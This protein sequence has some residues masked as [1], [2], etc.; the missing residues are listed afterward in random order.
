MKREQLRIIYIGLHPDTL[1]WVNHDDI[2][3]VATSKLEYF[4]RITLNPFN[5]FPLVIYWL[6][7]KFS[8]SKNKIL[9]K[10]L[11]LI[12]R[13]TSHMYSSFFKKYKNYLKEILLSDIVI[14]DTE[15]VIEFLKFI[16]EEKI[17]LILVNS[18]SV[19]P[20]EI[21]D[22]I[23]KG[24]INIHPSKLPKYRGSLPTLWSLKN[25]DSTSAV[26]YITLN[27]IIDGGEIITQREFNILPTD[28]SISLEKKIDS[29]VK[30]TIY[31]DILKF[32]D[33]QLPLVVQKETPSTTGKYSEY[34]EI[35]PSTETVDEIYNKVKLYPYLEPFFYTYII[36]DKKNIYIKNIKKN[37]EKNNNPNRLSLNGLK[38]V[39]N[40]I[41]GTMSFRLFIDT[42]FKY[43][44]YILFRH[45]YNIN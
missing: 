4:S 31:T 8:I 40:A 41:D 3:I 13:L 10:I 45:F 21:I 44:L 28:D 24:I 43:S 11:L 32:I 39:I 29:I 36:F 14:I 9:T 20:N 26:S 33:K 17:N 22:A 7:S 19:L 42:S 12:F 18:W 1:S 23:P 27:S 25:K 2:K 34:R 5:Y 37:R 16:K 38:V 6:Q 30:Q 15:N 35:K